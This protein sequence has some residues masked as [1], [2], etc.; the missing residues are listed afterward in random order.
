M[1][2]LTNFPM[3]SQRDSN[4]NAD[5]DCVP[6]SI[7]ACLEFLT[8]KKF[9]ASQVKDAAYPHAYIGGTAA[10]KYVDFCAQQGV[11]LVAM[12]GNGAQL[13][14]DLHTQ[15]AAGHPCLITEPDP[16]A[17]GWTH[18]CAAYKDDSGSITVMDPWIAQPVTKS[19]SEWAEQLQFNEIW[20]LEREETMLNITDPSVGNYFEEQDANHWKCKQTGAMIQYGNLALYRRLRSG[21]SPD[22]GGLT[23]LGLPKSNEK[24]IDADGNTEQAFE[25]G[26]VRYDPKHKY[27]NPPGAGSS[28]MAHIDVPAPA[29]SVPNTA[30]ALAQIQN[31][32]AALSKAESDLKS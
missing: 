32:E 4:P 6:A 17:P 23:I 18:V 14:V 22:L 26:L 3:L 31:A 29:Q 1:S 11:K 15:L 21:Q 7:A 27:D 10:I 19:N 2:E 16:Y 28:Y 24:A 25:R 30:D 8:D 20:Y 5:Y 12:D 9:T 13:V